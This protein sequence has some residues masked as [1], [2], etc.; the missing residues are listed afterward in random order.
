MPWW[1]MTKEDRRRRRGVRRVRR[2]VRRVRRGGERSEKEERSAY[3]G[4]GSTMTQAPR[5]THRSPAQG[6]HRPAFPG[7]IG[8]RRT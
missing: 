8:L 4:E 3:H 2:G 7:Q 6:A 5:S 1:E